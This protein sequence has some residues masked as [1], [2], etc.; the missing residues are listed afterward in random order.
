MKPHPNNTEPA[1]WPAWLASV[2]VHGL[3]LCAVIA[4]AS[5]PEQRG[6]ADTPD[7]EAGI[8]LKS[9]SD[10]TVM[11]EE[12]GDVEAVEESAPAQTPIQTPAVRSTATAG[13]SVAETNPAEPLSPPLA[14]IGSLTSDDAPLGN[15][16]TMA[17]ESGSGG[18]GRAVGK[19]GRTKVKLFGVEGEGTRFVYVLDR[20]DSMNGTPMVALKRQL[21]ASLN[22][23]ESVHQFHLI[24]F[25]HKT[26]IWRG[27]GIQNGRTA[28]ATD[29]NLRSV[30]RFIEGMTADGGTYRWEALQKALALRPDVV[31]FLT[32]A[33]NPMPG[34]DVLKA[35]T[36]AGRQGTAIQTIEFGIGRESRRDNFLKHLAKET[37]GG[38]DYVDVRRLE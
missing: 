36:R 23:L 27:D 20:S 19:I 37:G 14:G 12:E 25:N 18:V 8:V 29:A 28:F 33:D 13:K 38:Y 11:F 26:R 2:V 4:L 15:A 30:A 5:P 35:V 34:A 9:T 32:D 31:F 10:D 6:I 1:A 21:I 22:S 24:F 17:A 3:L 7:R 16:N